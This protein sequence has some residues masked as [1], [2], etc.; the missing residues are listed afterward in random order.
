MRISDIEE[1]FQKRGWLRYRQITAIMHVN[2]Q[3]KK[4]N[5]TVTKHLLQEGV[6]LSFKRGHKQESRMQAQN[7]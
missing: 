7:M 3:P 4:F 1:N 5:V 6:Y 2:N